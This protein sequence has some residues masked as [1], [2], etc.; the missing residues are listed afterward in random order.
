M[1]PQNALQHLVTAVESSIDKDGF[2][3]GAKLFTIATEGDV[4]TVDE[5]PV[6]FSG[7]EPVLGLRDFA[8]DLLKDGAGISEIRTRLAE[9]GTIGWLFAQEN[10]VVLSHPSFVR[11]LHRDEDHPDALRGR[12]LFGMDLL[13]RVYHCLRLEGGESTGESENT[14]ECAMSGTLPT[15]LRDLNIA[16]I[17]GQ[18]YEQFYRAALD[19]LDIRSHEEMST[20]A[21]AASTADRE[22]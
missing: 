14:G 12:Q 16:L 17:E 22:A 8:D 2:G 10:Y 15:V 18:P 6:D 11:I 5:L 3:Q 4:I 1:P 13:G 7:V 20:L 21:E 19:M 9:Q